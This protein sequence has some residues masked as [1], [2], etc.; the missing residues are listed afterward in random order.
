MYC[1]L[2][3]SGEALHS[4]PMELRSARLASLDVAVSGRF[5][6]APGNCGC[7]VV[8]ATSQLTRARIAMCCQRSLNMKVE[9]WV[10]RNGEWV[11]GNIPSPFTLH[12][13]SAS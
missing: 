9:E 4:P 5:L 11:M 8:H 3:A 12:P 13:N 10:M 6:R 1:V 7:A 2:Y